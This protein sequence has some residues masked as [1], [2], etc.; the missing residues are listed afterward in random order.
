MIIEIA[1]GV[2]IGGVLL[3][4]FNAMQDKKNESKR[5]HDQ[6]ATFQ[7]NVDDFL[8]LRLGKFN[9][10]FLD[11]FKIR[12]GTIYDDETISA[13]DAAFIEHD[14][15]LKNIEK[16][17]PELEDETQIV[18]VESFAI[19]ERIGKRKELLDYVNNAIDNNAKHL[20]DE[21]LGVLA[22]E[23]LS[24]N[25]DNSPSLNKGNPRKQF[26]LGMAYRYGENVEQDFNKAAEYL[27]RSAEQ[28]YEPAVTELNLLSEK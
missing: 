4:I 2:F 16:Y 23:L 12:L 1:V 18:L 24:F 19:A 5:A 10:R 13:K 15:L 28:G 7:K 22:N 21:S 17:K 9:V 6:L 26:I 14:L 20:A 25:D 3:W 8:A 11:A 27:S